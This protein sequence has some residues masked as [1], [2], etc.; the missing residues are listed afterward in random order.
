MTAS[1]RRIL[2]VDDDDDTCIMLGIFLEVE[3]EV[4][5]AKTIA[6]A[7]KLAQSNSFDG[8]IFDY[9]LSDGDGV[10]LCQAIRAFD[11]YTPIIFCSGSEDDSPQQQLAQGEAQAFIL[12]PVDL[13][14][15]AEVVNQVLAIE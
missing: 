1:R 12:K 7:L 9:H 2:V 4:K 8:Y 11:P 3:Y 10:A 5:T 6:E 15:L 14:Q 13:N